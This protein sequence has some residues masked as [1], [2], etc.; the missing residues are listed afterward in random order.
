MYSERINCASSLFC[1]KCHLRENHELKL[2]IIYYDCAHARL[3]RNYLGEKNSCIAIRRA[4]RK[5][6]NAKTM[7]FHAYIT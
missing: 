2:K 4:A 1:R 6:R 5:S 7:Q 3:K